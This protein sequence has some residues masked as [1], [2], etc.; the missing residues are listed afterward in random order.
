MIDIET[1]DDAYEWVS[2]DREA[3]L[4]AHF[5]L[6]DAEDPDERILQVK[7]RGNDAD[8]RAA[9]RTGVERLTANEQSITGV[10]R[11]YRAAVRNPLKTEEYERKVT[12]YPHGRR[13]VVHDEDFRTF[14]TTTPEK[15]FSSICQHEQCDLWGFGMTTVGLSQYRRK[16][17]FRD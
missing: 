13:Y 16:P 8:S 3:L 5:L 9:R 7:K 6:S 14:T 17:V 15:L 11:T 4:M 10:D 12:I 2:T 1:V